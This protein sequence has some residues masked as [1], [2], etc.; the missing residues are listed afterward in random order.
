MREQPKRKIIECSRA[1]QCIHYQ[2]WMVGPFVTENFSIKF[3]IQCCV[4]CKGYANIKCRAIQTEIERWMF[5]Y[6]LRA[7]KVVKDPFEVLFLYLKFSAR[8]HI[9]LFICFN[10]DNAIVKV[11]RFH[12]R[13][14]WLVQATEKWIKFF[15]AS[16]FYN[17]TICSTWESYRENLWTDACNFYSDDFIDSYFDF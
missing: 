13:C 3:E 8:L 17:R 1:W 4:R 5:E 15:G 10:F 6:I 14:I 2:N 9:R 7:K 16:C 12:C 11:Y